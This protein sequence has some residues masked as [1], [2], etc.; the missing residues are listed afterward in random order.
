[1]RAL[2]HRDHIGEG[3]AGGHELSLRHPAPAQ[4]G[5]W[6]LYATK[7]DKAVNPFDVEKE[8]SDDL[9]F[10][11]KV[12]SIAR[13][14]VMGDNSRHIWIEDGVAQSMYE[15]PLWQIYHWQYD[16]PNSDKLKADWAYMEDLLGDNWPAYS[17]NRGEKATQDIIKSILSQTSLT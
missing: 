7:S 11:Q 4:Y 1:M 3:S 8:L 14:M 10:D 13:I 5:H 17:W 9:T 16:E 12:L 2:V 6:H 15:H